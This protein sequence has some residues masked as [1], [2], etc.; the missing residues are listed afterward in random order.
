MPFI[1]IG[2]IGLALHILLTRRLASGADYRSL[3]FWDATGL[4]AGLLILSR[5]V[6]VPLALLFASPAIGVDS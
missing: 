1:W 4:L 3:L 6:D 2:L 5:F